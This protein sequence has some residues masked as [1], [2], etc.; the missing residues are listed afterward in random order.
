MLPPHRP[1]DYKIEIKPD[2][3]N[4]LGYTPLREQSIAELQATKQYIVDNLAKGFIE[5]S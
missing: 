3:E 4:V 1:Y 5:P 2:K